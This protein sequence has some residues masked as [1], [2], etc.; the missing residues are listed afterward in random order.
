MTASAAPT[1]AAIASVLSHKQ[2]DCL[3][4]PADQTYTDRSNDESGRLRFSR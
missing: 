4:Q 2:L 3:E 1:S